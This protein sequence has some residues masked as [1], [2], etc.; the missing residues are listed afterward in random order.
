MDRSCLGLIGSSQPITEGP[1]YVMGADAGVG[2]A[3]WS[4]YWLHDTCS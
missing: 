3:F 4:D 1:G 2:N